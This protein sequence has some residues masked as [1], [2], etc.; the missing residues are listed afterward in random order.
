MLNF[1]QDKISDNQLRALRSALGEAAAAAHAAVGGAFT[2]QEDMD[3]AKLVVDIEMSNEE[4]TKT[5]VKV[6]AQKSGRSIHEL[7]KIKNRVRK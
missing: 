1:G 5:K 4:M 2:I 6:L 3:I 7:L